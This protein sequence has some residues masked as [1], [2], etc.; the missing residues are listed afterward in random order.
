MFTKVA[1][2]QEGNGSSQPYRFTYF[3]ARSGSPTGLNAMLERDVLSTTLAISAEHQHA[4]RCVSAPS[5]V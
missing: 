2:V 1:H 4:S 5:M 3:L